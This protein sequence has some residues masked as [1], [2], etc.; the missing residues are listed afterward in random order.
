MGKPESR[1]VGVEL[2][3]YAT[4]RKVKIMRALVRETMRR[5]RK[6]LTRVIADACATL[7]A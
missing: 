6:R 3:A 7:D 5:D 2:A 4:P 1:R